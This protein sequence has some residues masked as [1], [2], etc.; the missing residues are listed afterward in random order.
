MAS[1]LLQS[2]AAE[3]YRRDRI[4]SEEREVLLMLVAY[5]VAYGNDRADDT[6]SPVLAGGAVIARH[7][8]WDKFLPVGWKR[9]RRI[10]HLT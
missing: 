7:E 4:R 3:I 2:D 6:R 5:P 10:G 1:Q 8:E 9:I